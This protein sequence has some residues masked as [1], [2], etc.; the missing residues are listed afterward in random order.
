MFRLF[1]ELKQL[2]QP[3]VP[4]FPI[5]K[6]IILFVINYARDNLSFKRVLLKYKQSTRCSSSVGS[7]MLPGVVGKQKAIK[8][9]DKKQIKKVGR[10]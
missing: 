7:M 6:N 2:W 10:F 1:L 5:L 4:Q 9:A 3:L 8:Q